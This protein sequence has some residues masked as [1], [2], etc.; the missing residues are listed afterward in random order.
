MGNYHYPFPT[1]A[2]Q[3]NPIVWG[4]SNVLNSN[5]SGGKVAL[6]VTVSQLPPSAP[7]LTVRGSVGIGYDLDKQYPETNFMLAVKGNA[8]VTEDFTCRY[9][10]AIHRGLTLGVAPSAQQPSPLEAPLKVHGPTD[11][12]KTVTTHGKL[13]AQ[14]DAEVKATLTV[15]VPKPEQDNKY[16]AATLKVHGVTEIA[17]LLV[18]RQSAE[19]TGQLTI[20]AQ[21]LPFPN[22]T[23]PVTSQPAA[24]VKTPE[25]LDEIE[26]GSDSVNHRP[27]LKFNVDPGSF[28]RQP[29]IRVQGGFIA[30]IDGAV[31]SPTERNPS[32]LDLTDKFITIGTS[33]FR[34]DH[35]AVAD[36][37]RTRKAR[38]GLTIHWPSKG[39]APPH[40]ATLQMEQKDGGP[41]KD[42]VIT[43]GKN[44]RSR[45]VFR[46]I[47]KL[48]NSKNRSGNVIVVQPTGHVRVYGSVTSHFHELSDIRFKDAIE[49]IPGALGK[50][51]AMRGIHYAWKRDEFP[52][53]NFSDR[54][55]LGMIA[56]EVEAI[57]PELVSRDPESGHKTI[58]YTR[59]TP[60]LVEAIKDQQKVIEAQQARLDRLEEALRKLGALS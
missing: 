20:N 52:D 33:P 40:F 14:V 41:V 1:G 4:P 36:P 11:L 15:G 28:L 26:A 34:P 23:V 25:E 9:S 57:C 54:R 55:Q 12:F 42:A 29:M 35:T 50:V 24:T 21:P 56:Q 5:V 13:T 6:N 53:E 51:M 3:G 27:E 10:A 7:W 46:F 31:S 39:K 43:W 47:G 48:K 37:P 44:K 38:Y 16:P 58:D 45:F 17:D 32:S 19:V 8:V 30:Q 22:P 49:P 59:V 2:V 18:A 60:V